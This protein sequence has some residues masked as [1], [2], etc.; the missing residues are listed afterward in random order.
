MVS[1]SGPTGIDQINST[2]TASGES[3]GIVPNQITRGG[4]ATIGY[5]GI[6][7]LNVSG[8]AGIDTFTVTG[9]PTGTTTL[10]AWTAGIR[11]TL[12]KAAWADRWR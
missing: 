8:T 9:T 4:T 10:M 11:T 12:R 7:N 3:I 5:S 6:E 1:D 2:S